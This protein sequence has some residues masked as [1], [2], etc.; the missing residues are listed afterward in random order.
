MCT[1][2]GAFLELLHVWIVDWF[3]RCIFRCVYEFTECRCHI[4]DRIDDHD[5]G[6]G[7]A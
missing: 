6:F 4:F 5:L 3:A 2:L 7:L 1:Y